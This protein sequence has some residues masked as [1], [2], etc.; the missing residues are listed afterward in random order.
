MLTDWKTQPSK[1]ANFL[2]KLNAIPIKI[3]DFIEIHNSILKFVWKDKETRIAETI[4]KKRKKLAGISLSH[5]KT[6]YRYSNQNHVV[7]AE[8][9]ICKQNRIKNQK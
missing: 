1:D 2:Q 8:R 5:F 7:L 9:H 4:L 3:P 6:F